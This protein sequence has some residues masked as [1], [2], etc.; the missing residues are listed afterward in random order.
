MKIRSLIL[1][2]DN[3]I[4]VYNIIE[5]KFELIKFKGE[6][7]YIGSKEKFWENWEKNIGY[8]NEDISEVDLCILS[9][10]E[11]PNGVEKYILDGQ[12]F[13]SSKRIIEFFEKVKK[14]G[15]DF[16]EEDDE[17]K[18]KLDS[19]HIFNITVFSKLEKEEIYKYAKGGRSFEKSIKNKNIENKAA[20]DKI[21]NK[22]IIAE[23]YTKR[24]EE[25]KNKY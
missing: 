7:S 13:W 12:N 18:I 24:T 17:V 1:I 14:V 10:E 6:R 23:F 22:S 25:F 9:K 2:E 16:I 5:D 21:K 11:I 19:N 20:L 15:I 3:N 4:E 8:I